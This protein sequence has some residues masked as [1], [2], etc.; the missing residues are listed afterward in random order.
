MK[1][2]FNKQNPAK[3][4]NNND[5]WGVREDIDKDSMTYSS[6]KNVN[7]PVIN[8]YPEYKELELGNDSNNSNVRAYYGSDKKINE[9]I[10]YAKQRYNAN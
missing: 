4:L 10:N 8:F 3:S 5:R 7:Q 6:L 9:L 2:V 1:R